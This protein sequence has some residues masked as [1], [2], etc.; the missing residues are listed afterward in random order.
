M[1][2]LAGGTLPLLLEQGHIKDAVSRLVVEMIKREWPQQWPGL[3]DELNELCSR[4]ETQTELVLLVLLR[5]A[6][7]VAVLQVLYSFCR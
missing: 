5:L 7:D 3:L 4:G 6:E 1:R 2:L